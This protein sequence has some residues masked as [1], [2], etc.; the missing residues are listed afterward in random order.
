MDLVW[1]HTPAIS[2]NDWTP[3][4]TYSGVPNQM[5][6]PLAQDHIQMIKT[7]GRDCYL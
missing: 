6:M 7:G 3:K 5:H 4:E 2:V 1:P